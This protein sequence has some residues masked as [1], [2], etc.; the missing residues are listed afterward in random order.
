[1]IM[2]SLETPADNAL[3]ENIKSRYPIE[4]FSDFPRPFFRSNNPGRF[5]MTG[6]IGSKEIKVTYRRDC[7]FADKET[8]EKIFKLF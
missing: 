1:M 7:P 6:I 3:L 5:L 2:Y 4:L 8:L